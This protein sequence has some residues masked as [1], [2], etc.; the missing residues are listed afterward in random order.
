MLYWVSG[1]D[2]SKHH[3]IASCLNEEAD[4]SSIVE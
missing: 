2:F 4:D 1:G 3:L